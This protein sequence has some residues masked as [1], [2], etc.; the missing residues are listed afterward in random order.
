MNTGAVIATTAPHADPD[1]AYGAANGWRYGLLGLGLAFV[2][3]PLYVVLPEHYAREYGVSLAWLGALLLGTRL[4]DAV[5]DPF[6]GRWVDRMYQRSPRTALRWGA[7]AA[8]MLGS[9]FALLFLPQVQGERAIM[10]WLGLGLLLTYAGFSLL[11]IAHL[12]WAARLAG[13][14]VQRARLMAWR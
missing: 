2:A 11:S 3:L 6:L 4:L 13:T 5:A 14:D 7:L 9:G 10:I 12:A 8:L 1:A